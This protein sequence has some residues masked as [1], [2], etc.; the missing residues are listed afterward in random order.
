MKKKFRF[1]LET[2]EKLRKREEDERLRALGEAQQKFQS[3]I[4]KKEDIL[5]SLDQ[6]LVER[7]NLAETPQT[8]YAFQVYNDH[9]LGSKVRAYQAEMQIQ[10]AKKV[11]EKTLRAYLDAKRKTRAIELLREKAFDE[12]K[13]E[14]RKKENKELEE[15]YVMRGAYMRAREEELR[16][17]EGEDI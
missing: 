3:M 17:E 6:S 16:A 11:V 12:F 10:K 1:R 15:L 4:R 7:E 8:I 2:V 5:K 9:I 14:L 13:I